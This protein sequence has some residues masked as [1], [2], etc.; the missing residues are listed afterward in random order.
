MTDESCRHNARLLCFKLRDLE[1]QTEFISFIK[2][3]G[4]SCSFP[5]VPLRFAPAGRKFGCFHGEDEFTTKESD[6]LVCL[7][8]SYRLEEADREIVRETARELF[9]S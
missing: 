9:M 1:D 5:Y 8:M 7:L 2:Q 3:R 4:I 6:R